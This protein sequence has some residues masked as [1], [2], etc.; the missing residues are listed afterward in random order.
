[1]ST[2][3]IIQRVRDAEHKRREMEDRSAKLKEDMRKSAIWERALLDAAGTFGEFNMQGSEFGYIDPI[4]YKFK[5]HF[6]FDLV[7]LRLLGQGLNE[8]P[9]EA[10]KALTCLSVLNLANNHLTCLPDELVTMT[11]L[12]EINV[13]KN[14]IDT[15]P[16]RIGLMCS[17]ERLELCNNCLETLP[18]TFGGLARLRKIDME[19]NLMRV[20]PENLNNMLMCD[21]INLNNNRLIRLPRCLGTMPSLTSVSAAKN[22]ITYIPQE[23][24]LCKTLKII[25]LGGNKIPFLP[26]NI[27][28]CKRITEICIDFNQLR[29]LPISFCQLKKLRLFRAEGNPSLTEPGPDILIGGAKA[30]LAYCVEMYEKDE[31]WRQKRTVMAVQNV[32]KQVEERK[33]ADTSLFLAGYMIDGDPWYAVGIEYLWK[34]LLPA[35]KKI[36]KDE[37]KRGV[38]RKGY[39]NAFQ[40]SMKEMSWAV[41]NFQDAYGSVFRKQNAWFKRC[42]CVDE[43]GRRKPCVPP[44]VGFMCWRP[45]SLFKAQIIPSKVRQERNWQEYMKQGIADAVA[46]SKAEAEGYLNSVDGRLWLTALA[47]EKAEEAFSDTAASETVAWRKKA[48]DSKK[49]GII[50]KFDRRKAR[51]MR[52]REKKASVINAQLTVAKEQFRAAREGYMKKTV[53]MQID[54]L[55]KQLAQ[56]PENVELVRLQSYCEKECAEVDD[57]LLGD[58]STTEES[59]DA[60]SC[61][62]S[63]DEDEE[64]RDRRTTRRAKRAKDKAA[65]DIMRGEMEDVRKKLERRNDRLHILDEKME[66]RAEVEALGGV[67]DGSEIPIQ[68][69]RT[70]I[71]AIKAGHAFSIPRNIERELG[72]KKFLRR[73]RNSMRGARDMLNIRVRQFY[74]TANGKFDDLQK[75]LEHE[76]YYQYVSHHV[77]IARRKAE[78]EFASMDHIRQN[79][80]GLGLRLIFKQ[81]RD[82]VKARKRRARR[83]LRFYWRIALRSFEAC[84]ESVGIAEAQVGFWEKC[85]NVYTDE[86]FY[87]HRLTDQVTE[88]KPEIKHYLP[89]FFVIPAPPPQLPKEVSVETSSEDE[90]DIKERKARESALKEENSGGKKVKMSVHERLSRKVAREYIVKI[91]DPR[92]KREREMANKKRRGTRDDASLASSMA[93]SQTSQTS[94]SESEDEEEE[95]EDEQQDVGDQEDE[96]GDQFAQHNY[97]NESEGGGDG[98]TGGKLPEI[99]A[100]KTKYE[101]H[102]E[103]LAKEEERRT[104]KF[105]LTQRQE[106]L[107]EQLRYHGTKTFATKKFETDEEKEKYFDDLSI[108]SKSTL[109]SQSKSLAG[110]NPLSPGL[111]SGTRSSTGKSNYSLSSRLRQEKRKQLGY[112]SNVTISSDVSLPQETLL[113]MALRDNDG[114]EYDEDDE[115]DEDEEVDNFNDFD[116]DQQQM[117]M[118]HGGPLQLAQTEFGSGNSITEFVYTAEGNDGAFSVAGSNDGQNTEGGDSMVSAQSQASVLSLPSQFSYGPDSLRVTTHTHKPSALVLPINSRLNKAWFQKEPVQEVE[119]EL[120]ERLELA[121]EYMQTEAYRETT[122]A[123]PPVQKSNM[124]VVTHEIKQAYEEEYELAEKTIKKVGYGDLSVICLLWCVHMSYVIVCTPLSLPLYLYL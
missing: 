76:L 107:T 71:L 24:A 49:L 31:Y 88:E 46:R 32:L 77:A 59:S 72:R 35:L 61:T 115:Y 112:I 114:S 110:G 67:P 57:E 17:L 122:V 81:W 82:F 91:K 14:R 100:P 47:Y 120:K 21:T 60:S 62:D 34:D 104:K 55:T 3:L 33:I 108:N 36:W 99:K 94:A 109:G 66:K 37:G 98:D 116:F 113:E 121:K 79:W 45:T 11:I 44:A 86:P 53:S 63:E 85:I 64:T 106:M 118:Q 5:E 105:T 20:M 90:D 10:C 25:R 83:D 65:L 111:N 28:N 74:R 18:I 2:S 26:E 8:F 22:N 89:Q 1:M 27:G 19:C 73:I 48:A 97:D 92:K 43:S 42:S 75:E 69:E 54:A 38:V 78:S 124:G 80:E 96:D 117:Q 23:L 29:E 68:L 101:L 95:E 12:K 9:V 102:L 93:T 6:G 50:R 119:D 15:L 16:D 58:N 103:A 123:L 40:Y 7:A 4:I 87:R 70:K 56:L 41:T 30:V 52:A 51:V 13:T 84:M 39:I